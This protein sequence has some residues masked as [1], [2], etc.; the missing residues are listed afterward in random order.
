MESLV[1]F[2]LD[3][4]HKQFPNTQ[5]RKFEQQCIDAWKDSLPIDGKRVLTAQLKAAYF[6]QR[7]AMG[8]KIC[9]YYPLT[10]DEKLPLFAD[11]GSD[12]LAAMVNLASTA[13]ADEVRICAKIFVHRGR[14]FSLEFPKAPQH[15]FERHKISDDDLEFESIEI[16]RNL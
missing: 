1:Q 14:L 12:V 6:V 16:I 13:N 11:T 8:A 9:F 5:L 15:Y 4:Y 3:F 10:K 2:L 7:Q